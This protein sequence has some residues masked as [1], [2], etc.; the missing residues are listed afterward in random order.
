MTDTPPRSPASPTR[1]T[2]AAR[3]EIR[4][5]RPSD[6]PGIVRLSCK[7]YADQGPYT[8]GQIMGQI[9]AFAAGTFVA[10]YDGEVAGYAATL[11]V[12]EARVMAPH[13]W[14]EITGAGYASQFN[15]RGDW[16]YGIEVM[17]DPA[18]RRLRL[19]KRLYQARERLCTDLGLRGIAFGGRLPGF[20][21]HRKTHPDPHGYVAA[22]RAGD[23]RDPVM[24]FQM[25]AGFEPV[26]ALPNY[27]PD[28]AASGGHAVLMVWR[29][30]YVSDADAAQPVT[31]TDPDT[32]RVAAV[33][34]QARTLKSTGEFYANVD[35]FVNIASEYGADFVVFPEHFTL[36]LLSCEDSELPPDEAIQRTSEHTA[37]FVEKLQAMAIGRAINIVGGSHATVT[38]DGDIQNVGYV[39]LRDGTVHTQE[40]LHP[41]PDE[42]SSWHIKG[43]DSVDVIDTD[44]GP[45]GVLI[46]YD[47]EFPEAARRLADQGARIVFVPYNTD[48]RH[49]HLR[50]RYCCQARAVENQCYVVTAG[51]V[52]NL[53]NVSNIDIQYA[54]S[55]ILTP[56]D[57]PFAR[58]GIAAEASENVEMIIVADLNLSMVQWA[59][60]QGSVRNLRDRRF[61][62]YRTRWSDGG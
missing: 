3:L 30:P 40:K 20:R 47:S 32:V 21:R 35:Y 31:R 19:G 14:D 2:N 52:G 9:N 45:V 7:V 39:F 5:A 33:Q 15:A 44:C 61:D 37:E 26:H 6:V 34:L 28:D 50:V 25:K 38:D 12:L 23:L 22:V 46:C 57:F 51:M 55:A 13:S 36:Q 59:R 8:A 60:A 4:T 11:R 16:L 42:R 53:D 17:V 62:L 27:A 48:T 18:F 10:L 24:S 56:C 1:A 49:G 29:N 41:T 58:D 54:Q 43:G